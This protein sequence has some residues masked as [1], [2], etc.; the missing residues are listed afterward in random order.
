M[1]SVRQKILREAFLYCAGLLLFGAAEIFAAADEDTLVYYSTNDFEVNEFERRMYLRKG[2]PVT[3]GTIGSRARN[4]QALSD[5]Y[6]L[7]VLALEAGREEARLTQ[8]E[9]DW[10]ADHAVQLEVVSL[11]VMAEVERRLAATDWRTEAQ[12]VYL[13]EHSAY[14]VEESVTVRSLLIR[15]ENRSESEALD[16]V[17]GLRDAA[18]QPGANFAEIVRANT[19]DE[20]A[21]AQ[22]GLMQN[23]RRGQTV[24]PFET[25]AFGLSG[26][27]AISEP[28]VSKFGVHLI[29]L[30][31]HNLPRRKDF[32]EV[33]QQI[34]EELKVKRAAEYR[35][36]I[37]QGA[38]DTALKGF[39]EHTDALDSLMSRTSDGLL[40]PD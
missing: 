7:K 27:G 4:L 13:A 36:A 20:A 40:G 3:D 31:E 32:E 8:Q 6:A 33:E 18:Q 26:P 30:L 12:E 19:E 1:A 17:L 11:Y 24:V 5:L 10:I 9:R 29:Q 25:A 14:Q 15:T 39:V 2:P 23:V 16:I 37:T 35:E 38:R 22:S 21:R 28:I 34:T